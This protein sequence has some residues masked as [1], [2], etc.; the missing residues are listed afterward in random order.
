LSQLKED[1][2]ASSFAAPI[3]ALDRRHNLNVVRLLIAGGITAVVVFVLCWL[4]TFLPFSSPSHVYIGLF[5]TAEVSSA[6]AL[7]EGTIW[8]LFFGALTMG[9]FALIYNAAALL[10]RR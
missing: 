8:S 4:G 5:T 7:I 2:M 3:D 9:L 1:V 6:H 10:G